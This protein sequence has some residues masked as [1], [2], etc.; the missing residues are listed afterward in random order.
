MLVIGLNVPFSDI[1]KEKLFTFS[2]IYKSLQEKSLDLSKIM[3]Y[4][5][6]SFIMIASLIIS[7]YISK[8]EKNPLLLIVLLSAYLTQGIMVMAPYSPLRTTLTSIIFFI[9][10]IGYLCYLSIE[11]EYSI[12]LAFI[13]PLAIYNLYI[14]IIL[15]IILAGI[16]NL[17]VDA[18]EIKKEIIGVV[19]VLGVVS[20]INW[21]QIY[22]GY[23][24][25]K[26][27]YYD[28][29]SIIGRFLNE[30]PTGEDQKNKELQLLLPKDDRYGFTAMTG[31]GWI[32]DAVKKYFGIDSS[33]KLTGIK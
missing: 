4:I 28:N 11:K 1:L 29:I 10:A 3:P 20:I 16:K 24:T 27:I 6:T 7:F 31:I 15:I 8:K 2:N 14:G 21:Y 9:I 26:K 5:I 30:N 23:Q 22:L 19:L 33:V 17:K 25:N 32:D 12:A 18:S 13:I